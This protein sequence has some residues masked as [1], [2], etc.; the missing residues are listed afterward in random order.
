MTRYFKRGYGI[1]VTVIL[2]LL[3]TILTGCPPYHTHDHQK[4]R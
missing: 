3:C 2:V 1:E 4:G